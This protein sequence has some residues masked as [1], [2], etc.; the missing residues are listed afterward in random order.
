MDQPNN[1]NMIGSLRRQN[2]I[3]KCT[4]C[5]EIPEDVGVNCWRCGNN[6]M[7]Y[8][9]KVNDNYVRIIYQRPEEDD[10]FGND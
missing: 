7:Y 1:N 2:T 10:G 8:L 6:Q 4:N 5:D 9:V 3:L